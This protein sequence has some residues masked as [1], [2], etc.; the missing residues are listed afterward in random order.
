MNNSAGYDISVIEGNRGLYDGFDTNG[1]HSSAE[2]AKLLKISIILVLNVTKM[3]RTASAIVL[4]C[5]NLD[6]D[7]SISGVIL[8]QVAGIRHEK[9]IRESIEKDT[10]IP[11]IGAIPRFKVMDY[12]PSRHLGLITPGEFV[13]ANDSIEVIR[14]VV[15]EYVDFERL[16]QIAKSAELIEF[17]L[18]EEKSKS[19]GK[20]LKLG[21]FNDKIFSFYYPENLEAFEDSGVELV[22]I[23]SIAD[24]RLP[25]IDGLYIGGG[26]P[27]SNIEELINNRSLMIDVK[28]KANAGLPVYAECGGLIYLSESIEYKGKTFPMADVFPL[29][30]K[31]ETEPQG[32][33]YMNVT[34][35][36]HNPYFESGTE[37]KG[38]EF[39]YSHVTENKSNIET[40]LSVQ[41]GKGIL[42]GR[43]G[44]IYKNVFASYLHIHSLG[45]PQWI[46]GMNNV[47]KKNK[48]L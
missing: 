9:I 14:K 31:M 11:V 35:D 17:D 45:C 48:L 2:L 38:H 34:V 32:H 28:E 20:G 1:T 46:E 33:G 36:K 21:Y 22:S 6:N 47:M 24:S 41:R 44:I 29:R 42:N 4:G 39:H 43:D 26:F 25:E 12:L 15:S 10:G 16:I 13:K 30:I 8:N 23:S 40:C 18:P 7:I 3:T 27:E 37:I 19:D 5:K